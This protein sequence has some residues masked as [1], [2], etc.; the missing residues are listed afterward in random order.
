MSQIDFSTIMTHLQKKRVSQ[1]AVSN[2]IQSSLPKLELHTSTNYRTNKKL[3]KKPS[4]EE[5]FEKIIDKR[6]FKFTEAITVKPT[7]QQAEQ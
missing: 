4:C 6:Y 5:A 7:F 2:K 1:A 3:E